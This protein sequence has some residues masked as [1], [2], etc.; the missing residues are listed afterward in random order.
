[1]EKRRPCYL[2]RGHGLLLLHLA[3]GSMGSLLR[4]VVLLGRAIWVRHGTAT[5]VYLRHSEDRTA[6]RWTCSTSTWYHQPTGTHI[7]DG[8][9]FGMVPSFPH[10]HFIRFL[11]NLTTTEG[12][13][14]YFGTCYNEQWGKFKGFPQDDSNCCSIDCNANFCY[15]PSFSLL[16]RDVRSPYRA[17][18]AT[19]M[20]ESLSLYSTGLPV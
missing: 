9:A 8:A 5:A 11:R 3:H 20:D 13:R 4:T 17:H 14:T 15:K 18:V 7:R 16:L 6:T 1:V 10:L 19:V 12:G 2:T